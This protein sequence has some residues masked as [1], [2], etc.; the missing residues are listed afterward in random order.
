MREVLINGE[1][2]VERTAFVH[3]LVR[4]DGECEVQDIVGIGEGCSHCFAEG[5]FE[6]C[7]IC[8]GRCELVGVT[9]KHEGQGALWAHLSG[10]EVVLL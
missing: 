3:A 8:E 6:F 10:L 7:E 1:A 2:E 9:Y 4:L 5:P